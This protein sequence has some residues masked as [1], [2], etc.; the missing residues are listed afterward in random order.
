M[1]FTRFSV[2]ALDG[3]LAIQIT[4]A[5][6]CGGE[7]MPDVGAAA[8][9]TSPVARPECRDDPPAVAKKALG[10]ACAVGGKGD[11][12]GEC[13]DALYCDRPD[14]FTSPWEGACAPRVPLG[15][16]CSTDWGKAP[17]ARNAVCEGGV[18]I[19]GAPC[20]ATRP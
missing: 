7:V 13:E 11:D 19:A 6:A 9:T 10:A 8:D 4:A 2:R 20:P 3:L 14:H 16:S 17:C 18:C 12:L 5:V 1:Q 15:G